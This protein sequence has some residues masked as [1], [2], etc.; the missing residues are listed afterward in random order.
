MVGSLFL[1]SPSL[2][3][4]EKNPDTCH[5]LV[6]NRTTVVDMIPSAVDKNRQQCR[7]L[8][9]KT[10]KEEVLRIRL[11]YP[12]L[13]GILVV[14]KDLFR[15]L[16]MTVYPL[17]MAEAPWILVGDHIVVILVGIAKQGSL[18]NLVEEADET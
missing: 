15:G 12:L 1:S 9:W 13:E 10:L 8:S 17:K 18:R 3:P 16:D 2:A 14:D 11:I 6:S 5:H 4:D 7:S